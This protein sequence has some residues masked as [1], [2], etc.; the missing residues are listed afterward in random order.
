MSSRTIPGKWPYAGL[1][2]PFAR[3][4]VPQLDFMPVSQ[5]SRNFRIFRRYNSLKDTENIS[6]K[7]PPNKFGG[8]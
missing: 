7:I 5:A 6:K 4:S 8:I 2:L 3:D 1:S